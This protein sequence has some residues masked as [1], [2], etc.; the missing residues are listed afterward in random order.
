M[1]GL[2]IIGLMVGVLIIIVIAVTMYIASKCGEQTEDEIY[3]C[4][5]H[6]TDITSI[7]KDID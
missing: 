2:E 4:D 5:C 3:E 7:T 6:Y 1:T